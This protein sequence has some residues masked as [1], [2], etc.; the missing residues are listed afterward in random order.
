MGALKRDTR[1]W[2]YSSCKFEG[3]GFRVSGVR[4]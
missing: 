1:S 2:D 3:I 4:V